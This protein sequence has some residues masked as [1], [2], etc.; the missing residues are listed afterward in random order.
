M[1]NQ[2]LIPVL[3]FFTLL[4]AALACNLP[5]TSGR[6]ADPINPTLAPP[7]TSEFT[8]EEDLLDSSFFIEEFDPGIPDGWTSTPGWSAQAGIL[9]AGNGDAKLEIPGEW[10]DLS[11]FIRLRFE[12]SSIDV[13]FNRSETGAYG[14]Q[15]TREGLS[16]YWL[17]TGGVVE[18]LSI[19]EKSIDTG[20]HDLVVRQTHGKVEV[21]LDGEAVLK[22]FNLGLSPAGSISLI[23]NGTGKLEIDRIV[24]APAGMGPGGVMPTPAAAQ[25]SLPTTT[26][27]DL[28]VSCPSPEEIASVNNDL[29]LDFAYDITAGT[30]VCSAADGSVDLSLVEKNI[31][32]AILAMRWIEFDQPLPWTEL[33]L[34]DWFVQ[35][36]NGVIVDGREELSHCCTSDGMIVLALGE[37]SFA[38]HT[39]RF[40][41]DEVGQGGFDGVNGV[42]TLMILLAH[43]ARH[44]EGYPHSC[45]NG[46]DLSLAEMGSWAVDYYLNL[47]L[48]D[49]TD[50][51]FMRSGV[52]LNDWYDLMYIGEARW[53]LNY[54]F[55]DEP[56]YIPDL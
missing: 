34:Y 12:S 25:P 31:Y 32:H 51:E 24:M 3:C 13:Q 35:A 50:P 41:R 9:S 6:D 54:R 46:N 29:S 43:E 56:S 14:I 23:K 52:Q 55:C 2:K 33:T 36:V 20:W 49:H 8:V 11:L 18:S 22:Q 44:N 10:Q 30:L 4:L 7:P 27:E 26:I 21:I 42:D 19:T 45:E 37:N 39:D 47:W 16:L 5:F 48:A 1:T 38:T 17:P 53:M 28:M 40:L 15:L